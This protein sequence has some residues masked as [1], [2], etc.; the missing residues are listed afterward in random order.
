MDFDATVVT[1]P[2]VAKPLRLSAFRAMML[3]PARIGDP[4]SARAFARP[5]RSVAGRLQEWERRGHVVTDDDPALYLHEYTAG[6]LTVRGLVGA[7]DLSRRATRL[8]DRAIWPHEGIHPV[9]VD[10]LADRMLEMEM[11]PAP[12]LLVHD[13]PAAVRAFV[14]RLV[15][16]PP[17]RE[18]TD[19]AGQHQRLWRIDAPEDVEMLNDALAPS[20]ALIA[21]GHHRY[22]AYLRLQQERPGTAW[23]SGLAMLVDQG[24]TGLFLGAI[25]RTL[26]GVALDDLLSAARAAGGSVRTVHAGTALGALAPGRL[27]VT[28][29]DEWA[30]IEVPERGLLPVEWLHLDLVPTLPASQ[31]AYHHSVEEALLLAEART[32]AVLL[33]AP[34]FADVVRVINRGRLLPEKATSFQPKP[35]LGVLMRSLNVAPVEQS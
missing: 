25:H 12:I 9:Q 22:A 19:R 33:P 26:R 5:Y 31:V 8:D 18:Y 3:S 23:D 27:T 11:N 15:T 6:G 29:G 21:D 24:D 30:V 10:E 14:R 20:S 17:H 16:T 34:D 1:P 28:D 2:Y 4:A 32:S 7:L 13:G 35:S